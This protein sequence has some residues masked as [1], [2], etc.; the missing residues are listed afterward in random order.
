MEHNQNQTNVGK[1]TMEQQFKLQAL[2]LNIDTLTE[3]QAK[4]YLFDCMR[5]MMLKDNL[6]KHLMTH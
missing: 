3:D 1:L 5:Q 2:K 6:Y 4:E